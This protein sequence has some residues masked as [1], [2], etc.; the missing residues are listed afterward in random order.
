MYNKENIFFLMCF[1]I[2]LNTLL[3]KDLG[4]FFLLWLFGALHVPLID[5]K[6]HGTGVG[7][8]IQLLSE[9][10]LLKVKNSTGHR[11]DLNLGTRRSHGHCCKRVKP[12]LAAS[13]QQ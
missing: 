3:C 8:G 10:I 4:N 7:V 1:C 6:A 11:W 2:G 13:R 12:L 9:E 5:F